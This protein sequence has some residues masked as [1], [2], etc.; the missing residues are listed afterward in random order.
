M[1]KL[2]LLEIEKIINETGDYSIINE[3]LTSLGDYANIPGC[4]I[5]YRDDLY[6]TF[7]TYHHHDIYEMIYIID[8]CVDFYIEE[9]KYELTNGDMALI[10]SNIL[11]KLEYNNSNKCKRVIINFT[12][13]YCQKF[14]SGQTD[15]LNVFKATLD[16]G[17]H[18]ISFH[19]D[20]RK[21]LEKNFETMNNNMLSKEFGADLRFSISF[22]DIMLLINTVY[23]KLPEEDLIQKNINDPY[24]VKIIE[25]IKDNIQDKILLSDIASHVSLSIS[26]MCHLFKDVTGTTIINYIIKKRLI[27]AKNLLKEGE[28]IKSI[29]Y[30]CGFPDEASF[31][32]FFKKE[33]GLSPKKYL[34]TL[35][36]I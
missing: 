36:H 32:R 20:K 18:K 30:K 26:R 14:Q 7:K 17:I 24:V 21:I 34:T 10:P 28:Q 16:G 15:I 19:S 9:K 12:E 4:F 8:G 25:Y 35:K 5:M 1:N 23:M 33:Y 3:L 11:H 2:N 31:F 22:A 27:L 29:Y 6:E 13:E